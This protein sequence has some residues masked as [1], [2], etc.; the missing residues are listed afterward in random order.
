MTRSLTGVVAGANGPDNFFT[1][2]AS[3]RADRH[4]QLHV[5]SSKRHHDTHIKPLEARIAARTGSAKALSSS[6]GSF[7]SGTLA[8]LGAVAA[9]NIELNWNDAIAKFQAADIADNTPLRA[10][11]TADMATP[12]FIRNFGPRVEGGVTFK[13]FWD[14]PP[15]P[16]AA[17]PPGPAP[18]PVHEP[19]AGDTM[20]LRLEASANEITSGESVAVRVVVLNDSYQ[21]VTVD[22]RLLVGPNPV[23]EH[24]RQGLPFPVSLE[25]AF[26]DEERNLIYL[27]PWCLYGRERSWEHFPPG[28]VMVYAYLLQ[29]PVKLAAGRRPRRAGGAAGRRAA[30]HAD[31]QGAPL[32]D[33]VS[34]SLGAVLDDQPEGPRVH[35][36][37]MQ[38]AHVVMEQW[39]CG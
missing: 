33:N 3:A 39:Q 35:P 8:R 26:P 16:A 32:I 7:L 30:A 15:G 18:A 37:S 12:D 38:S 24:P 27:N 23:P 34:R 29:R 28:R 14:V 17:P 5:A 31:R 25:P 22:R 9:L 11:D 10:V 21:P 2:A 36:P 4:E 19:A 6:A 1:A 13:R 20:Q